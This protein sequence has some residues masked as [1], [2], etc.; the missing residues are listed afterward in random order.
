MSDKRRKLEHLLGIAASV[1][2][3]K[4]GGVFTE[5]KTEEH[6]SGTEVIRG[7][8]MEYT[9]KIILH[10]KKINKS[11]VGFWKLGNTMFGN[12][13][14]F[15]GKQGSTEIVGIQTISQCLFGIG[16]TANAFQAECGYFGGNPY[17]T[18]T[19]SSLIYGSA[20]NTIPKDDEIV[21]KASQ[22]KFIFSSASIVPIHLDL[23]VMV[24]KAAT[25]LTPTQLWDQSYIDTANGEPAATFPIGSTGNVAGYPT[26][27]FLFQTPHDAKTL[28]K[29]WKK[30]EHRAIKMEQSSCVEWNLN[31]RHNKILK[32]DK[33]QGYQLSGPNSFLGT[34][35]FFPGTIMIF[36]VVRSLQVVKDTVVGSVSA[37]TTATCAVNYV[38]KTDVMLHGVPDAM[39]RLDIRR[40]N[41]RIDALAPNANQQSFFDQ[42]NSAA[43]V[44][45][46][47]VGLAT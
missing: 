38:G 30:L 9:D 7:N 32:R 47:N 15:A 21:L 29:F 42:V 37:Y 10:R 26:R 28:K 25:S 1:A 40:E 2:G 6:Q 23:Y 5:T 12:I 39:N 33:I 24:C 46:S 34:N 44:I 16:T 20:V 31:I 3:E 35:L 8:I 22:S 43:E 19:N 18:T 27:D 17:Q 41:Q 11:P 4:I 36:G 14:A 45:I 13:T